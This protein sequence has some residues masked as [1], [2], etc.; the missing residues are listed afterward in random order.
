MIKARA[1]RHKI[2]VEKVTET[3]DAYGDIVETWSTYYGSYA[4]VQPLNGKE[5]FD[6][7]SVQADVTIKFRIRYLQGIIPKMRVSYNSRLFDIESVIDVDERHKETI[8]MCKESV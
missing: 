4:E 8:L 2:L 6:S 7:Q 1:K 3:Q 5:Y